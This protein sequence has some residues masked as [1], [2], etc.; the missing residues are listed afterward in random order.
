[1]KE[2]MKIMFP[3][4]EW[5]E[6]EQR[7]REGDLRVVVYPLAIVGLTLATVWLAG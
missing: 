4:E 6:I 1:M 7:W 3:R 5:G 2:L